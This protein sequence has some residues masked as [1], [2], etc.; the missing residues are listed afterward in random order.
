MSITNMHEMISELSD[1]T[2]EMAVSDHIL[3]L[4]NRY[5]EPWRH[6]HTFDHPREMFGVLLEHKDLVRDIGAI[7]WAIMYHDAVYDPR[8]EHGR[9]EELSAQLAEHELPNVA[10][11]FYA[12]QAALYTRATVGH[13]V[14]SKDSDLDFFLDID[15][16]ILGS[17]PERY[18][19]YAAD[20]RR[21][22]SHV[23]TSAYQLGR[24]AILESLANRVE[25]RGLFRTPILTEIYEHQAQE[26]IAN[27]ISK[28]RSLE[29][30][31]T[32]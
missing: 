13:M 1:I 2:N 23:P 27:E 28:L 17:E 7:G 22:Y 30:K 14:D 3:L 21:E 9:N 4:K 29:S 12:D 8:A 16:T 10:G 31:Q 15:L 25:K 19:K 24:I 5:D 11:Q 6:Y 32:D 20:V 26:N 18:E